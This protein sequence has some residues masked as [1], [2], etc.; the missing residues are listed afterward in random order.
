MTP[1]FIIGLLAALLA[2]LAL[3]RWAPQSDIRR[4]N[5]QIAALK[6]EMASRPA[7]GGAALQ[8]VRSMLNVS[9]GDIDGAAKARRIR[10]RATNETAL[11]GGAAETNAAVRGPP[12]RDRGTQRWDRASMSNQI[13]KVKKAWELRAQIARTNLVGRLKLDQQQ[14]NAFDTLVEAMN[15][16]LGTSI[17]KWVGQI[18][19]QGTMS[20]ENGIRMMNELSDALVITYDELDRKMPADWRAA[21]G[22]KF[23]VVNFIDP[24]VMTPLQELEGIPQSHPNFNP[25]LA[26]GEPG[27][28]VEIKAG[29]GAP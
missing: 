25:E 21:A 14:V 4:A 8:G 16:R 6:K 20:S 24:E 26:P 3:G 12:W 27:A 29:T 28:S 11:A 17:D 5:E 22:P 7:A 18:K 13:E 15:I 9:Q 19:T 23:E 1:K 10:Q 2:G